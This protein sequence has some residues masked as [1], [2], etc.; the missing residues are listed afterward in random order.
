MLKR[1]VIALVAVALL[2]VA[3][4]L[5]VKAEVIRPNMIFTPEGVKG[6]DTSEYQGAID[7]EALSSAGIE[8]VYAKASEG[9][10]HVDAQFSATCERAS[11]SHAA[12]GAYHFFSFEIGRAHV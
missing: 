8:F 4:V 7:F 10:T 9:T 6:I 2:L 12:L 11:G 5:G 3:V 1:I